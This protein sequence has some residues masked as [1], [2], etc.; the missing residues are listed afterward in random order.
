MVQ[1]ATSDYYFLKDEFP[2]IKEKT[3]RGDVLK[4]YERV[5]KILSNKV[6]T[7]DCS[8]RYRS[9]KDKVLKLYTNWQKL[10]T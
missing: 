8:C 6:T 10:N 4:S 1:I 9:Y 7:P 2:L 3:L 5:E